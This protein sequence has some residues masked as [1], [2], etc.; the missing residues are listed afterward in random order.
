MKATT[1]FKKICALRHKTK[2]VQGSQGAGKTFSILLRW[3]LLAAKSEKKQFCSIVTATFPALESGAIKDFKTIVDLLNIP[4]HE[5]KKPYIFRIG[6]W[7]FQ[8]FSIDKESKGLGARRDRL[9]INEANRLPWKIAK[10]LISR[11]HV[12]RIFDFNPVNTFWAHTEFVD[13]KDCD[14]IKLTYKDNEELPLSEVEDIEKSAPWGL[15]PDP[16]HWRIYGLGEIGMSVGVIFSDFKLYSDLPQGDYQEAVGIDFGWEDPLAIVKA[17]VDHTNK[18]I[19]W[20]LLFYGSQAKYEEVI[21]PLK[22]ELLKSTLFCDHEPRDIMK[23][24]EYGL[25]ARNANKKNGIT[26]D[27]RAIK[28]YEIFVHEDSHALISEL[29][30]YSYQ[31]IET[32]TGTEIIPYPKQNQRDH[33][34]DAA[35]YSVAS[36]ISR[37]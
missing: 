11:T 4:Y 21:P 13:V 19:Y 37:K 3:I 26:A 32:P 27:I 29:T 30:E 22:K 23:L 24:R 31:T 20:R 16:N 15:R 33:A 7:T 10:Q 34:I 36:I 25:A 5:T 18:R 17:Y 6:L 1:A 8:F 9:Y 35:K 12:E 28:Q 14:F 2:V